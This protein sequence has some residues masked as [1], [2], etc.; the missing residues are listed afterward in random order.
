MLEQ[1]F[2]TCQQ[3]NRQFCNIDAPLQPLANPPSYITAIYAKNK[4]GIECQFSL[5]IKNICSAPIST[6][7]TSSL[8][9][10]PSATELDPAGITLICPDKAPKSSNIF[11]FFT[12]PQH[13]AQHLGMFIYNLTMKIIRC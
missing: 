5:Q 7:I 6:P 9:I 12:Y 11:I 10:L 4:A 3:A 8:G 2:S 13:I 1:Q